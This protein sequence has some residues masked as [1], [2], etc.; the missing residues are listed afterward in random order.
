MDEAR[1]ELRALTESAPSLVGEIAPP[2]L[3]EAV[4]KL[5]RRAVR[6]DE[7]GYS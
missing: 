2:E 4:A 3:D 1:A 6:R 5:L 7:H